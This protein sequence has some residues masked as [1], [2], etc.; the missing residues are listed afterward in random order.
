MSKTIIIAQNQRQQTQLWKLIFSA[1]NYQYILV[2][3]AQEPI[4]TIIKQSNCDLLLLDMNGKQL[5]PYLFCR[6]TTKNF[7]NLP[8]ILTNCQQTL[9]FDG[10]YSW[11][12]SQGAKAVIP[13][14]STDPEQ[15]TET[16]ERVFAVLKW[17]ITFNEQFIRDVLKNF[18]ANQ[19]K[20]N[21]AAR[22]TY[23]TIKIDRQ[24]FYYCQQELATII[25]PMAAFICDRTLANNPQIEA[26]QFIRSIALQIPNK[27]RA[28][29]FQQ[30]L[31]NYIAST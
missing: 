2:V 8:I 18:Q 25:G 24:F 5:N 3:L 9:G 15:I 22:S 19:L 12:L 16:L 30:R 7:P 14:L 29:Q 27:A 6:Q 1:L 23:K 21:S 28:K 4:Q 11:A 13:S 20:T 26:K 31:L 17:K 10:Q